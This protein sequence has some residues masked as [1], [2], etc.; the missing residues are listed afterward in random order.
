MKK[1]SESKLSYLYLSI[2][3]FI[4]ALGLEVVSDK[5]M[6]FTL[7]ERTMILTVSAVYVLSASMLMAFIAS[8]KLTTEQKYILYLVVLSITFF[9]VITFLKGIEF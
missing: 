3:A 2:L 6:A 5:Y 1:K 4:T 9:R 7:P 8:R